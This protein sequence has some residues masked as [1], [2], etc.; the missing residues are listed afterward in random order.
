[1]ERGAMDLNIQLRE[2]KTKIKG[3]NAQKMKNK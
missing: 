1:M 3:L 2:F